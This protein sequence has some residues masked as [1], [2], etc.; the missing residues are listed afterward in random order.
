MRQAPLRRLFA[1]VVIASP[2]AA[3]APG[4][5][6]THSAGWHWRRASDP[7]T[8]RLVDSVTSRWQDQVEAAA[9]EWSD[10]SG[11]LNVSMTTGATDGATRK[12]CPAP[13]GAVRICNADY[14]NTSWA[15]ITRVVMTGDH[16]VRA[17]IKLNDRGAFAYRALAC[18]EIGHA[19][20]LAHRKPSETTSC[21]T[22]SVMRSQRH[23]DR[24]DIGKIARIYEH[25]DGAGVQS[26]D[27]HVHS[28]EHTQ[29]F[30]RGPY[31]IV[32]IETRL[33]IR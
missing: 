24:H 29:V 15:A 32:R 5:Q 4:A 12:E 16:I 3:I 30:H 26:A 2:L 6:A 19:L 18:H 33:P 27:A 23:P 22:P 7:F 9:Q 21:M 28:D 11:V 1:V 17:K 13:D 8:V 10:R 25:S 20:G 31:T 14:G